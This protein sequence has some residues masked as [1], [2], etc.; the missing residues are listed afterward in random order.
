M[1]CHR[2]CLS[3]KTLNLCLPARHAVSDA[4]EGTK[5]PSPF[6]PVGTDTESCFL[7]WRL[8]GPGTQIL[9]GDIKVSAKGENYHFELFVGCNVKPCVLLM[10]QKAF[11]VSWHMRTL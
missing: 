6:L 1:I 8:L 10:I 5:N 7:W 3:Q 11:A 9:L 2:Y 4:E